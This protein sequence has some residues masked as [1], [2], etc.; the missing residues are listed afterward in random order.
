MLVDDGDDPVARFHR[1]GGEEE[2]S[3]WHDRVRAIV[4]T[5]GGDEALHRWW[6]A[7]EEILRRRPGARV[8]RSAENRVDDT[9]AALLRALAE[10][11]STR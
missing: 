4:V 10:T 11:T 3:A 9:Y 7:L 8:I 6:R 2:A 5:E 1:R